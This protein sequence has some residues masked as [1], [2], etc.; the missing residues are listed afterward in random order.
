MLLKKIKIRIRK[1]KTLIQYRFS[2]TNLNISYSCKKCRFLYNCH[3]KISERHSLTLR[4]LCKQLKDPRLRNNIYCSVDGFKLLYS[5]V[6]ETEESK[7][8]F[9][10]YIYQNQI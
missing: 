10:K 2:L 6:T 5:Y 3:N 9:G 4:D 8:T 1:D 7:Q